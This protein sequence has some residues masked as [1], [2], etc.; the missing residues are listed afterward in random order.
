L[1]SEKIITK[2]FGGFKALTY[3]GILVISPITTVSP[4]EKRI[5]FWTSTL[6]GT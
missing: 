3:E 4:V 5:W 6:S 2:R 1:S